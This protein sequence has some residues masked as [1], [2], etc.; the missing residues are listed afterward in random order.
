MNVNEISNRGVF[1][2]YRDIEIIGPDQFVF[3]T[4][5]FRPDENGGIIDTPRG[6]CEALARGLQEIHSL[7]VYNLTNDQRIL[8]KCDELNRVELKRAYQMLHEWKDRQRDQRV[9]NNTH[10]FIRYLNTVVE[11]YMLW[12][13]DNGLGDLLPTIM[14]KKWVLE[15][16][17]FVNFVINEFT[18]DKKEYNN[19][20]SK[21][22]RKYFNEHEFPGY[23]DWTYEQ[24]YDLV[25]RYK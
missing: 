24:C 5:V 21:A 11:R 1:I 16:M 14:K 17:D 8:E 25:K 3:N 22:T 15:K 13:Q 4:S 6:E 12:Y 19:K 10:K 7:S 18:K 9:S 23:P 2:F 20:I